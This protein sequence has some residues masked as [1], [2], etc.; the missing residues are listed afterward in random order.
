MDSAELVRRY[1][2]EI[3]DGRSDDLA[4]VFHPDCTVHRADLPEPIRGIEQLGRFFLVSR[5]T[6]RQTTT[7]IDAV[8]TSGDTA[9][10]RVRHRVTFA[11]PLSTPMGPVDAEGRTVEW[12]AMAWFRIA[13]G[14]IAEEWVQRDEVAIFRQLGV[15]P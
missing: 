11:R 9:A 12:A 8:I 14:R 6:I 7:T 13:D 10:A 2:S 15:V 3:V 5:F 1:F 4:S